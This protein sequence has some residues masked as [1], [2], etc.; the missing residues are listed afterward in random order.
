MTT[1]TAG[2]TL[3]PS[4]P[5]AALVALLDLMKN[6]KIV[7]AQ[8]VDAMRR[9]DTQTFLSLQPDKTALTR[10]YEIR[11]KE[12]Q[13]RSAAIKE[14]DPALRERVISEQTEL[15]ALADLSQRA[16]LRMADAVRRLQER[17]LAAARQAI[18][19]ENLQYNNGGAMAQGDMAK[20]VATAINQHA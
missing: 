14:A 13:A 18:K 3:V 12:I 4:A 7:Y 10:D 5:E 2:S 6:L 8:E 1:F 9:N 20:P 16:A 19:Q 17:L 11:V 15:A